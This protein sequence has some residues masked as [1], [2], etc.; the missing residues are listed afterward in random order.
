MRVWRTTT[1]LQIRFQ[2]QGKRA[3]IS[4]SL[5]SLSAKIGYKLNEIWTLFVSLTGVFVILPNTFY[6]SLVLEQMDIATAFLVFDPGED[7][8][9]S[10]IV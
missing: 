3:Q 9:M 10:V 7:V 6:R 2:I 8:Y 1:S 5:F 4:T